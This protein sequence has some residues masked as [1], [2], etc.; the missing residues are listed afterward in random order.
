[1]SKLYCVLINDSYPLCLDRSS[2]GTEIFTTENIEWVM[3]EQKSM[4]EKHPDTKYEVK[5]ISYVDPVPKC[6]LEEI[7][8]TV[9][10]HRFV[11][12][13]YSRIYNELQNRCAE[14]IPD[15]KL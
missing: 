1:M 5:E 11:A 2:D 6:T 14:F 3:N 8:E 4:S 12:G 9:A 7:T 10:G 15:G 13:E